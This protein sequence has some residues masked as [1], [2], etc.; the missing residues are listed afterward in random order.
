MSEINNIFVIDSSNT[1][2]WVDKFNCR[3]E[4]VLMEAFYTKDGK[5]ADAI[6]FIDANPA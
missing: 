2:G 6:V 3:V 1:L 4:H 5:Y